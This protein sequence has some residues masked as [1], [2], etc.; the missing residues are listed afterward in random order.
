M[1]ADDRHLVSSCGSFIKT[2]PSSPS[3]GIDALSHHS[4]SGSSDA[5]GGFGLALGA[6]AN[7]LDSPPMFAGAGLGGTPCRKGYEDCAGGIMED[8]AIKCEYMLNAIPK[9]LC[10]VCGDIAS[11]YHYGVASCEACKAFFKRTI[12]GVR[13]DRVRG[14]RQKYKRRLDS[15]S[16]PY[17][18]LQ[19]SPPAKKPLTKIVSYL[20]VAEPDK[21]YAMPPPGMPEGDIKALTTLCDLADRELVVIIGWAK[22]IP[23]FSSLSLGDQMSLLQSAWMEILILGIVYR[24]LPYDDKLVYAEDYIMDEE[25]SRLAGL[26]ELYRAIL[27]LVRRYKKLKVEKEEFVTLKAL[28]LANSDS[29]YIEDLEAV[30]KLQDLLHE[31]LQDYELSQRHEEPRRTGKLLLTLPLLRQTAAKAVQHFHSLKLQGK[32]PMHKLFLEMLEAKV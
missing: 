26:L 4:P 10:L 17:L 24:S 3:S 32:V 9:R 14:G 7:G 29:M 8:S 27:Q 12:Q 18:S 11:G 25:R 13:L 15:E 31:A 22:H 2:E 19:I 20:L 6:H 16:S 23:G 1:S 21:L 30:Q 28:A 5:S